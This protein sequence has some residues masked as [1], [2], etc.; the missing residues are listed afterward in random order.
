MRKRRVRC[1]RPVGIDAATFDE[2]AQAR[3]T[4]DRPIAAV[5][6][7]DCTF[8]LPWRTGDN[9]SDLT[10]FAQELRLARIESVD[11]SGQPTITADLHEPIGE[12][13]RSAFDLVV[14][15]GTMFCCFDVAK[16]WGNL[17]AMLKPD[18]VIV[19]I[20]GLTGYMGRSYY[21]FHPALFRDFYRA[22][23]FDILKLAV[24][25]PRFPLSRWRKDDAY[26][27]ISPDDV[28]LTGSDLRFGRSLDSEASTVPN[29]A[30]ILCVARRVEPRPFTRAVPR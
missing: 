8:H 6:A 3:D 24:R 1:G 25:S 14:D 29:D 7:G 11:I 9:R 18:G 26:R 30:T 16:V 13:L 2:I 22:N 10:R 4:F 28:Y 5:I 20:A 27:R 12:G 23:G 17:L 21:S 19:H 15:A